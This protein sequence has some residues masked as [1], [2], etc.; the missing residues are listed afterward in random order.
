MHFIT[1]GERSA[2]ENIL[3]MMLISVTNGANREEKNSIYRQNKIKHVKHYCVMAQFCLFEW[4][5]FRAI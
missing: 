3:Q 2:Y 5:S 4:L 1:R